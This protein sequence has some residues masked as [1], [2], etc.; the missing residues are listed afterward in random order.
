M[1]NISEEQKKAIYCDRHRILVL[2]G[3]G[4]GKTFCMVERIVRQVNE[5]VDPNSILCLT[6]TRAAAYEMKRRYM[7]QVKDREIP[8][9][10]TF[11]AFCYS[12]IIENE[13]LMHR[14]GYSSVP[15]ICTDDEERH[16]FTETKLKCNINLSKS[17]IT[18]RE[19]LTYKEKRLIKLW[20]ACYTNLLKQKNQITF[21][22]LMRLITDLFISNDRIVDA[23][24]EKYTHIYVDELQ[25]TSPLQWEFIKS[26]KHSDI[27]ATGDA[28]QSLYYFRGA[29]SSII[30]NLSNDHEYTVIRLSNNYRSSS[31][32]VDCANKF[33]TYADK[34][35][36]IA[37]NPISVDIGMVVNRNVSDSNP[38]DEAFLEE[39]MCHAE[40]TSAILA[41]TNNTVDK[42]KRWADEHNISYNSSF[43][44]DLKNMID[45]Y[46]SCILSDTALNQWIIC[47]LTNDQYLNYLLATKTDNVTI[48]YL[49]TLLS[50]RSNQFV[51]NIMTMRYTIDNEEDLIIMYIQL[52]NQMN[53][54]TEYIT[55]NPD[56][57]L[58]CIEDVLDAVRKTA[59]YESIKDKSIY[60][61]TIHS[62]KGL[63]FSSVYIAETGYPS[64]L[65][66]TEENNNIYYVGITRAKHLLY[67]E[68]RV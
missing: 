29:D 22:L 26:M 33:S 58:N 10:M 31:R 37:M 13:E 44:Y 15:T 36:R 55:I 66:N 23:Y 39:F 59:E 17:K 67:L 28:L 12:L 61:G 68:Q 35:Y 7:E 3:A 30:K 64:F 43:S 6:F 32:I 49:N 53:L 24:K 62:V 65:L 50:Y 42:L 20:D 19:N 63:E 54:G 9:F 52:C 45:V 25:D 60:I 14:L 27:Y 16:L 47:H 8:L 41:R 2:A 56:S 5:G 51:R 18:K 40:G 48:E 11:H 38:F 57:N 46:I 4:S 1:L 34:S 21:D